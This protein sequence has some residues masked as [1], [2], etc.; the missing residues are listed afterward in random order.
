MVSS[1]CELILDSSELIRKRSLSGEQKLLFALACIAVVSA[2]VS[3]LNKYLPPTAQPEIT[4]KYLPPFA[5]PETTQ[6]YL[7]PRITQ[8][9]A[10]PAAVRSF[11]SYPSTYAAAP[12]SAVSLTRS[13][14]A[15]TT[16]S[17]A[18][19]PAV[20]Y[21]APLAHV[22]P[23]SYT[24]PTYSR[25]HGATF[26]G[27]PALNPLPSYSN[28]Y[29]GFDTVYNGQINLDTEYYAKPE[30]AVHQPIVAQKPI[31]PGE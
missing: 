3:H 12:L 18:I 15:P 27:K 5:R 22:T 28:V 7:P 9:F 6:K 29:S 4:Q 11:A 13:Y 24:T 20:S 30:Y 26:H 16:Y 10:A 19:S 2:D 14:T 1:K 25:S 21:S 17:R 8:K 23:L 31:E